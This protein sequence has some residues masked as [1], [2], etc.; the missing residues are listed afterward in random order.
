MWEFS[1]RIA[2]EIHLKEFG[3]KVLHMAQY[4]IDAALTNHPRGIQ[5]ASNYLFQKWVTNQDN[6]E[7]AYSKLI[8]N[9][10]KSDLKHL[11]KVLK[12]IMEG[13]DRENNG[14]DTESNDAAEEEKNKGN[15]RCCVF[16]DSTRYCF[17][18]LQL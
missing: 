14:S 15:G 4:D 6:R 5:M 17:K 18:I 3:V 11:V 7:I 12:D 9:L 16:D 8:K 1:K 2:N 13:K 10:K